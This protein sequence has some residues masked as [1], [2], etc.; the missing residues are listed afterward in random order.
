MYYFFQY[1]A[2]EACFVL[3]SLGYESLDEIVR[4][5]T[6]CASRTAPSPRRPTSTSRT[7]ARCP[8]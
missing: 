5:S 3:A 1:V 2:E 6:F 4:R 7:S 8:T